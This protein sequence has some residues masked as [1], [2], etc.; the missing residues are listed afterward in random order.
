ML[1]IS[2]IEFEIAQEIP[3][4]NS[5]GIG[6]S[7]L[8]T[9]F[10]IN[11]VR[12]FI[13]NDG[14]ADFF[15]ES[16]SNNDSWFCGFEYPKN[17]NKYCIYKSGFVWAG[18]RDSNDLRLGGSTFPS[19][20]VPGRLIPNGSVQVCDD[21]QNRVYRI[22]PDFEIV[23]NSSSKDQQASDYEL[24]IPQQYKKDWNEWPTE[25]GAPFNDINK[26][27]VYDSDIDIPGV[28]GADQTIWFVANHSDESKALRFY[29][30]PPTMF[31][32]QVTIWGYKTGGFLKNTI[33]K[34]YLLIN[35]DEKDYTDC[36][37]GIWCDPDIGSA[38]DDF[39]GC[40]TLL[41]LGFCYN[42]DADDNF[43]LKNPPA[44][45][46]KFL[47][48]PSGNGLYAFQYYA[49]TSSAFVHDPDLYNYETGTK[50]LY[51]H[52]RGF[53]NAA[54]ERGHP[55]PGNGGETRYPLSGCPVTGTGFVDGIILAPN[56]RRYMI[57]CGP[58]DIAAGDTTEIIF[59]QIA[60]GGVE[61]ISNIEAVALLKEYARQAQIFGNN[62][63]KFPRPQLTANFEYTSLSNKTELKWSNEAEGYS[64]DGYE[65]QGYNIF[66][67]P[68]LEAPTNEGIKIKTFDK[69]DGI[70]V[71][72]ENH[73]E[74][75][76]E[77][78]SIAQAGNDWGIEHELQ[79]EKDYIGNTELH[80]GSE[81]YY[82]ITNY[83]YSEVPWGGSPTFE[84]EPTYITVTV[85]ESA[86]PDIE[87]INVFPNPYYGANPNELNKYQRY[88]TFSHLPEEATIK[89]FNLAGQL[90]KTMYKTEPGQFQRWDLMNEFNILVPGG[91]Y[92]A[93]IEMPQL[94][95]TKILKLAIIPEKIVPDWY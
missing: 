29:G 53:A 33:F 67:L 64:Q 26:N 75:N 82:A 95:E 23:F 69:V 94:G 44:V 4:S 47:S 1:F 39:V 60:A 28:G 89:I 43:Y 27:H 7:E 91:I 56:D 3:P 63:F 52:L 62:G 13:W 76:H 8:W 49:N 18:K 73:Y 57:S 20:L 40:D 38:G 93:Y 6:F 83:S 35:K 88:V 9:Q 86:G 24:K 32:M 22:R 80:L 11:D 77:V 41:N 78:T 70:R 55:V 19:G 5:T 72:L 46:H 14:A 84:S 61:G 45:G 74:N 15:P 79:I 81:Y 25:Y 87:K 68:Y 2:I 21:S 12:T 58:V 71:I 50:Y 85:G 10:D 65:F 17:S 51:N 37:F 92:I 54:I 36:F 30:S 59:A 66:Q 16:P 48:E 34:K 42:A 90:V 31:E